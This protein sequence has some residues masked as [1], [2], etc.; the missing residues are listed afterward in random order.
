[1]VMWCS[2]CRSTGRH[3]AI[4]GMGCSSWHQYHRVVTQQE[5]SVAQPSLRNL[6]LEGHNV[7]PFRR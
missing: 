4:N 3:K 7:D 6:V 5:N 1:M 2:W